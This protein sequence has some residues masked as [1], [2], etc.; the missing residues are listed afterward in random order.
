MR[1]NQCFDLKLA[2][3]QFSELYFGSYPGF[4]IRGRDLL[5]TYD[6]RLGR[7]NFAVLPGGVTGFLNYVARNRKRNRSQRD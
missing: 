4:C 1:L 3:P 6:P 2:I 5:Q 7:L